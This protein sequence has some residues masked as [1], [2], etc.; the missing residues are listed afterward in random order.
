MEPRVL[1]EIIAV[2]RTEQDRRESLLRDM[3]PEV[4]YDQWIF[5][6]EPL[7]NEICLMLLVTLRHQVE[8]DLVELAAL[9]QDGG[10]PIGGPDYEGRIEQLRRHNKAGKNVGWKW[11]DIRTTLNLQSYVPTPEGQAM[12]ALHLLTNS[13][14]HDPSVEPSEELK[15]LL[16]L[17]AVPYAPLPESN[18]FREKLAAF[19][20]LPGDALYSG[21]VEHLIAAATQYVTTIKGQTKLSKVKR[22]PAPL[23]KFAH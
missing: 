3:D 13:Y 18:L 12:E 4:A 23:D 1:K 8:R 11:A 17:P 9:A 10:K 20:G 22:G 7:V 19:L 15:S 21:I 2:I 6:D 5:R 14:K 16:N